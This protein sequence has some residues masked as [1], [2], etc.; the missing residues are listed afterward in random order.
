[1]EN[2]AGLRLLRLAG[3]ALLFVLA[4]SA[5]WVMSS[6]YDLNI[7][8]TMALN[9]CLATGLAIVVRAGRLSLAQATFGGI[10]GYVSGILTAQFNISYWLAWPVAGITA[11]AFGLLL[12][13]TSLRLQGFYFAIATFTFSQIAIIVLSAWTSETGGMSGMFGLDNPPDIGP[14]SFSNPVFYY[15]FGLIVLAGVLVISWLCSSGSRFGRGL[16]VLGEDEVVAGSLGV[17][18]I[19]Y[20]LAAFA[21][22]SFIGGIAG[23]L[24]THFVQG[25]SPSDIAPAVSVFVLVMVM[26]GGTSRLLGPAVGAVI[27]TLIPELL[28][29]S[30]EWSMVFYGAFLLAYVF[31]FR[32]GL[33]PLLEAGVARLF[34]LG[35]AGDGAV[36]AAVAQDVHAQEV[37]KVAPATLALEHVRCQF[38]DNVVL[39][40]I[41]LTVQPGTLCGIIGPNGAGKTTLFNIITGNARLAQGR[42][43][44]DGHGIRPLPA[45]MARRGV[46]RTFQHPR[47]LL[48]HTVRESLAYAAELCG[49]RHDPAYLNWV[50]DVTRLRPL[51]AR[52]GNQLSHYERR[53]LTIGMAIAGKPKLLLLDEPLAGLDDTETLSLKEQIRDIHSQLGCTILLIEHKLAVVMELCSFLTVLDYGEVIADGDPGSIAT[54]ETVIQAYLGS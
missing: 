11:G 48:Q 36:P 47:V 35:T 9:A 32:D 10:G 27:L 46:A 2:G 13:I 15:Y 51:L 41:S 12:G 25:I 49:A 17:P 4:V 30:A 53:L 37:D 34:G 19:S 43:T 44:L 26:A 20:R 14:F 3:A 5:P 39:N 22:S 7:L 42:L 8:V 16:T 38:G 1:M 6:Q 23:S 24:N 28:R 18:A 45:R 52:R 54:N 29:A 31:L 40:D 21:I 50:I 33:L